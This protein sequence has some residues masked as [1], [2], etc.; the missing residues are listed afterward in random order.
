MKRL[1]WVYVLVFGLISSWTLVYAADFY[2]IPVKKSCTCKGTLNGTRWCDNGDGT[3]TDMTTCLVWLKDADWG[4]LKKWVDCTTYD[5]AHTQAASLCNG[6]IIHF[7]PGPPPISIFLMDGSSEGDWRLPTKTE[8][9]N[10]ANGKEAVRSN[11]MHAFAGVQ[12]SYYW[13][14]STLASYTDVAWLVGMHYGAVNYSFKSS[15]WYVW[16]VRGG[17]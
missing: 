16:P 10:L 13:S 11:N 15:T 8:L 12:S 17:N 9:Y 1:L 7:I 2:V 5:D 6:K 4:G 3:V 14:S